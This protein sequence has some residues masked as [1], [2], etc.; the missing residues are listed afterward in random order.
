M[1]LERAELALAMAP[2]VDQHQRPGSGAGLGPQRFDFEVL[3]LECTVAVSSQAVP[4]C[5]AFRDLKCA[6][7]EGFSLFICF[8]QLKKKRKFGNFW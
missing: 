3:G 6:N 8:K 1:E 5:A 7:N 2:G 4:A